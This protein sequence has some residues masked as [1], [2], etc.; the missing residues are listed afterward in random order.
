M[1]RSSLDR[2]SYRRINGTPPW[3]PICETFCGLHRN[4]PGPSSLVHTRSDPW[5]CPEICAHSVW[6]DWSPFQVSVG[7]HS[8][9]PKPSSCPHSEHPRQRKTGVCVW[10]APAWVSAG[11][12]G[13][14]VWLGVFWVGSRVCSESCVSSGLGVLWPSVCSWWS[15]REQGVLAL[16]TA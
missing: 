8:R 4:D 12:V 3:G 9:T 14:G 2:A 7:F 15:A 1:D 16:S 6:L 5:M 11:C 13:L 10:C